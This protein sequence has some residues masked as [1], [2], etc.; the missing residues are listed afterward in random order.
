VPGGSRKSQL[1]YTQKKIPVIG[2]GFGGCGKLERDTFAAFI[3]GRKDV[4]FAENGIMGHTVLVMKN[5]VKTSTGNLLPGMI[6][7]FA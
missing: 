1:G 4:A 3:A 7:L 6:N 5:A 2:K